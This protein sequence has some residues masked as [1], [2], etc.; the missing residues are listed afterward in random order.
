M[1][2][3]RRS[4]SSLSVVSSSPA[5]PDRLQRVIGLVDAPKKIPTPIWKVCQF[6]R[7]LLQVLWDMFSDFDILVKRSFDITEPSTANGNVIKSVFHVGYLL[8]A[9]RIVC[10]ESYQC[11]RG[12]RH[13]A[14]NGAGKEIWTEDTSHTSLASKQHWRIHT[15]ML[16]DIYDCGSFVRMNNGKP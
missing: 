2:A 4:S 16:F 6:L 10:K 12:C 15:K 5:A 9:F 13:A 11:G 7:F 3:P 14:T 1:W 8:R